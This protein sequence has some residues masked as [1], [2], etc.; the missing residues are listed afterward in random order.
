MSSG[1]ILNGISMSNTCTY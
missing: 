1:K